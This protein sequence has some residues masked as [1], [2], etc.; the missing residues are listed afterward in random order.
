MKPETTLNDKRIDQGYLKDL[1]KQMI[2][3]PTPSGNEKEICE[4]I[5]D[6]LNKLGLSCTLQEVEPNR[7]NVVAQLD[8]VQ[9]TTIM[10]QGHVD[11]I[12]AY[13]WEDAFSGNERDGCI[14]GRGTVDMKG[15]IGCVLAAI[16]DVIDSSIKPKKNIVLVFTVDEEV[17]KRGIFALMDSGIRADMAVCCEPTNLEIAIGHK[18]SVPLRVSTKG[19]AAHGSTPDAGVNAIYRMKHVLEF[20]ES[21]SKMKERSFDGIGKTHGT[22]NVGMI[23][24]GDNFLLVPDWCDIWADRRTLPGETKEDI[25]SEVQNYLEK[26]RTKYPDFHYEIHVNE[27]PD[28]KWPRIIERGYKAVAIPPDSEI[29]KLASSAHRAVVGLDPAISFLN[30]WTET[31]FLVNEMAIPT[32]IFGPGELHRAHSITEC[33]SIDQLISTAEIYSHM[34]RF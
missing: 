33:V 1:V 29:V 25:K 11:T 4:L 21:N 10:F 20:F 24:G 12:P 6:E 17:E 14:H 18:G 16:K 26:V 2:R 13:Q 32:I 15:A 7:Q 3:I 31:D 28:W 5:H 27:R 9:S 19:K 34:M 30:G 23:K 22:Y 8:A